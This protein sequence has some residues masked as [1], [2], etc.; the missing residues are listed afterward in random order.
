[1]DTGW[2]AKVQCIHVHHL[3]LLP[4]VEQKTF[5]V[6]DSYLKMNGC[7]EYKQNL[8]PTFLVFE[9][10]KWQDSYYFSL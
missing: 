1:M 4:F 7:P 3:Y 5:L 2:W 10:G 6:L 8:T 9:D